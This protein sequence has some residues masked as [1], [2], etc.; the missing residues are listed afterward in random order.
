MVTKRR[1]AFLQFC[2]ILE[3]LLAVLGGLHS[4][5]HF[6][7]FAFWINDEGVARGEL[8]SFVIHYRTVLGRD[9][10]SGSASNL[11]LN[12]SFVQKSLCDLAVST[13]T[14]RLTAGHLVPR[15]VALEIVPC[16]VQWLV[17]SFG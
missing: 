15:Q 12:P 13:L 14:P 8:V 16:S 6:G 3:H 5:V 4:S 7:D 1:L 10:R 17:K 11:K 2:Q 9:L